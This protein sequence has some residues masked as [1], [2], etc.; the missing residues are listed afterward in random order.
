MR[1]IAGPHYR[2]AS[3]HSIRATRRAIPLALAACLASG[4]ATVAFQPTV[5][6][7]TADP[8]VDLTLR[9]HQGRGSDLAATADVVQLG[10]RNGVLLWSTDSGQTWD[11][12]TLILPREAEAA[13][14]AGRAVAIHTRE[15]GEDRLVHTSTHD[16]D[17]PISGGRDWP[18][19]SNARTPDGACVRNHELAVAWFR[20]TD[21]GW[22]VRLRTGVPVGDDATPQQFDLGR[23][24]PSRG[25]AVA[26]SSDRVYVAW[27]RGQVLK[28]RRF[29]IGSAPAHSLH[30]LGTSDIAVLPYGNTP[31]L[32]AD[33]ARVILA[34]MDRAD[35]KV[36]RS[37]NRGASFGAAQTLRNEPFPSEIGAWPTTVAIKG[38][39]VAI[40]AVELGG[41]EVLAGRGLGY[42]STDGGATYDQISA[43]TSGRVVA[44]LV[45]PGSVYR[46]AEIWDVSIADPDEHRL[47]FRRE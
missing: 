30:S 6:I 14:C 19:S 29:S 5:L 40:G 45:R 44:T 36:R 21:D 33:G 12:D 10:V 42:K 24:T 4:S 13:V 16:L 17:A 22:K 28:L 34:M 32:G 37:T 11:N 23:G 47:R 25:L 3:M 27:F 1:P 38:T 7:V 31:E 2:G 15:S 18:N 35:L 43:H 41:I 39:R 20:K 46:Y 26:A 9:D 8:G